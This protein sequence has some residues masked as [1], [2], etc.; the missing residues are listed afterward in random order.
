MKKREIKKKV[1]G[2]RGYKARDLVILQYVRSNSLYTEVIKLDLKNLP[3]TM[4]SVN[5]RKGTWV[6]KIPVSGRTRQKELHICLG[7]RYCER[8]CR[9]GVISIYDRTKNEHLTAMLRSAENATASQTSMI[10]D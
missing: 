1:H 3:D 2:V 5:P 10:E 7:V 9:F 6:A 8:G 4:V